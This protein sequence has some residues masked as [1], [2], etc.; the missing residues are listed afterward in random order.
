MSV[1]RIPGCSASF[2]SPDGLVVTNHHCAR[3]A[4]VRVQGEGENLLDDGFYASSL[5]DERR[6]PDYYADQLIHVEDVSAEMFARLDAATPVERDLVREEVTAEISQRLREQFDDGSGSVRVQVIGLYQG[7]RYSAYVFRRYTD[8]RLVAAAELQLGFFGGDPDNFTYPR[9]ALDFTFYRIYGPDGEPLQPDHFLEW[10]EAGVEEGDAVFVVGNPGPTSRGTTMAQ[11]EFLRDVGVPVQVAALSARLGA[12]Q[13]FY[14]ADPAT[15]EAL[16]LRN[17]MFSL[18]NSL[19]AGQ[20]RLAA[21]RNDEIMARRAAGEALFLEAIA[22][23]PELTARFGDLHVRMA[24]VQAAKREVAAAYGAFAYWGSATAAST[25]VARA[26]L[27]NRWLDAREAGVPADTVAM[28]AE[29]LTRI[30]DQPMALDRALVEARLSELVRY[31]GADH[32]IVQ[33]VLGGRAVAEEARDLMAGSFLTSR[34]RVVAAVESE[35]LTRDDPAM[36]LA[37]ALIPLYAEYRVAWTAAQAAEREISAELGRARFAVF[38]TDVPPDAT[39]SPRIT[40]GVVSSYAYNGTKAPPYTTFFGLYDRHYSNP[41]IPDWSLPDRWLPAPTGLYLGTPLNF[42]STA[43][44]YGG[45]SG[46]PAVTP[47]RK[48]V[49]LNFDRNIQG[50]S[51]DYIYLPQQG[52]NVMV[53]VRAILAS[54]DH[55]YDADRLVRELL[56]H[57]VFA[58]EAEADASAPSRQ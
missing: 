51:R 20:G 3:G 49:G 8:V 11:L 5:E 27:A 58:T 39:F 33:G 29:A 36:R 42:V 6:I 17:R 22:A 48:I 43:D 21:L 1:L 2:V 37:G 25:V 7:G 52:R 24:E 53:D 54:L 12:M 18:S 10:S 14:E 9:Y 47:G 19:K 23:D 41:G 28:I 56:E 13:A 50:L 31:L 32:P 57:R 45:N 38:G 44:T 55:V 26:V 40:D 16:G 4:I 30:P 15:G 46:S 35:T 34:D